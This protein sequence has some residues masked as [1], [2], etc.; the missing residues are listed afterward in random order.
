LI[1]PTLSLRVFFAW[2]LRAVTVTFL[3]PNFYLLQMEP[4][5]HRVDI[6]ESHPKTFRKT[7]TGF[8]KRHYVHHHELSGRPSPVSKELHNDIHATEFD[9]ELYKKDF[10]IRLAKA[11]H[12]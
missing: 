6:D 10:L 3:E 5:E 4:I 9:E 7:L 12:M 8:L 11:L 1:L 2:F